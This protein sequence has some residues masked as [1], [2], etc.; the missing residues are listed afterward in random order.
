MERRQICILE[1]MSS[2]LI[3]GSV[4]TLVQSEERLSRKQ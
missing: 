4:A 1:T 2:I 3:R